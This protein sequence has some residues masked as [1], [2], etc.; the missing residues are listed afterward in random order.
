MSCQVSGIEEIIK[1]KHV[2][3]NKKNL[4]VKVGSVV[5]DE[6]EDINPS[7]VISGSDSGE[8]I[9]RIRNSHLSS[10]INSKHRFFVETLSVRQ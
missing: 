7:A 8:S 1:P 9:I 2:D 10:L 3:K 5:I 4:T 6:S